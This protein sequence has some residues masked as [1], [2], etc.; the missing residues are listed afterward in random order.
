MSTAWC[1]K[2]CMHTLL[3]SM[4]TQ[5]QPYMKCTR[6]AA[7]TYWDR[8]KMLDQTAS[9]WEERWLFLSKS[10]PHP[11]TTKKNNRCIISCTL[12]HPEY[13]RSMCILNCSTALQIGQQFNHPTH[14]GQ[15]HGCTKDNRKTNKTSLDTGTTHRGQQCC[16]DFYVHTL[17][18]VMQCT[19]HWKT[20]VLCG[21]N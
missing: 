2:Y 5:V 12:E 17:L 10:I 8:K 9:S 19:L 3:Q 20:S 6:K 1:S 16:N 14:N 13:P 18:Y 21:P 4:R 11:V 15:F 7:T